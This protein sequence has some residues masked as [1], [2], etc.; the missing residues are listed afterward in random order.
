[1]F[2]ATM[3]TDNCRGAKQFSQLSSQ[4]GMLSWIVY[5]RNNT[6]IRVLL[7]VLM[8]NKFPVYALLAVILSSVRSNEEAEIYKTVSCSNDNL[9]SSYMCAIKTEVAAAK[10]ASKAQR[11]G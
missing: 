3:T 8:T 6:V 5:A 4:N 7:H 11:S 1:M 9:I 2:H 10:R